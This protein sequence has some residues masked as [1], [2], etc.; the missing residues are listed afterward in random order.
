MLR[1]IWCDWPEKERQYRST[2]AQGQG[3]ARMAPVRPLRPIADLPIDDSAR[4]KSFPFV[5][6]STN[7]L[8]R[9][10]FW[11]IP[12]VDD[13]FGA[14]CVLGEHLKE[15]KLST[16]I[17]LAGVVRWIGTKPPAASDLAGC[18]VLRFGFAHILTIAT[19]GG[20]ILGVADLLL[21]D[22]PA[23]AEATDVDAWGYNFATRVAEKYAK[24]TLGSPIA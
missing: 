22:L 1:Q 10:Q 13:Q 4:M 19:T 15:G 24:E 18:D 16:R 2:A 5:P 3:P 6:K 8:Q 12:L 14:G 21:A 9:G 23:A 17:F 20:S 7:P 11:S